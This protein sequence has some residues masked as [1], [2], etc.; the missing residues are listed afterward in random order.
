[1]AESGIMTYQHG[2]RRRNG[3]AGAS[4]VS[5][6]AVAR[7]H[8]SQ[9]T[10]F[11]HVPERARRH[12]EPRPASSGRGGNA[13]HS[14][15]Q[16]SWFDIV[17]AAFWQRCLRLLPVAWRIPERTAASDEPAIAA[18]GSVEV[19]HVP[20]ACFVG[21]CVHGEPAQARETALRRLTK[22]LNG[23]NRQGAV[24]RAE[25][26][27]IQQQLEPLLWR[28][29][30]RLPT[31]SD[32]HI[33]PAPRAPKVKLWS[34]PPGWLAVVQMSGRPVYT[35]VARGDAMVLD[36]ITN[37]DWVATGAPM[38]RVHASGPVRWFAGGFEVAVPVMPRRHNDLRYNADLAIVEHLP[39][40]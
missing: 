5:R 28:I 21:T 38:I 31:V 18:L 34:V 6:L 3:A 22:Y 17:I 39:A 9:E 35:A 20:A 14:T 2:S 36:A 15:A 12:T 16:T 4:R 1:M 37:T 30:V 8:E 26:M 11:G 23:D 25:R 29:S 7:S 19:R 27:L 40:G 10:W 24:L 13:A 33:A 32:D